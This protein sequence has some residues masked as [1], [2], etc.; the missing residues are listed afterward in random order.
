MSA[1]FYFYPQPSGNHLST[2]DL[3]ENLGEL[4]SEWDVSAVDGQ[5]LDGS[6]YRSVGRNGEVITIQRDRMKGSEALAHKFVALQNH[7]DRGFSCAFTAD[8]TKAWAAPCTTTPAGGDFVLNVGSNPFSGFTNQGGS[9][10]TPGANDYVVI[11]NQPPGMLQEIGQADSAS[12]TWNG[13]GS[14]TLKDRVAFSYP[15]AVFARWYRFWP[16]LK[17]PQE[18]I[19]TS[20][21]TNE[22]GINWSLNIR[23]VVDYSTLFSF[24]RG[25]EL[26]PNTDL[27]S[28]SP[29][30]GRLP[31]PT[32]KGTID[33]IR[34]GPDEGLAADLMAS[35]ALDRRLNEIW[36]RVN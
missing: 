5:G 23:L 4:F 9:T 8:H 6:I 20:I 24:H 34:T 21:I 3:D 11:E 36:G 1:K 19:G 16:V 28:V 15:A 13:G 17:R 30:T 2:I 22:H 29:S 7:L 27:I 18:D 14:I 26:A 31:A 32:G 25:L 12:L 10:P 35:A 33:I